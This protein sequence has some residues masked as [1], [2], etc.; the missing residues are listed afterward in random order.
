MLTNAIYVQSLFVFAGAY[1]ILSKHLGASI[2]INAF[3]LE[4][5]GNLY[6]SV[7]QVVL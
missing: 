6:L 1:V 3:R 7:Y 5:Y 4:L 2:T